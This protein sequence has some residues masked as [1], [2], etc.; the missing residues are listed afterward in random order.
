MKSACRCQSVCV[1][2]CIHSMFIVEIQLRWRRQRTDTYTHSHTHTLTHTHCLSDRFHIHIHP[3]APAQLVYPPPC[4]ATLPPLSPYLL[5]LPSHCIYEFGLSV[6]RTRF[7]ILWF[8]MDFS[9]P[10]IHLSAMSARKICTLSATYTHTHTGT[11]KRNNEY[12]ATPTSCH[13]PPHPSHTLTIFF[14]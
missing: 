10:D 12:F 11:Y 8:A 13:L 3:Y 14:N 7:R 1:C 4:L 9:I 6:A 2:S 5:S